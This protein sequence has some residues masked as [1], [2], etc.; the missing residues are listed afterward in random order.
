MRRQI[1]ESP[2]NSPRP[3][4]AQKHDQQL[5]W[6]RHSLWH[7]GGGA[8]GVVHQGHH[9]QLMD[10]EMWTIWGHTDGDDKKRVCPDQGGIGRD[11]QGGGDIGGPPR[12]GG[13]G[14]LLGG[15]VQ[16]WGSNFTKDW[17]HL[18]LHHLPT[19]FYQ[20][21]MKCPKCCLRLRLNP[22][23]LDFRFYWK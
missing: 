21:N 15:F 6:R 19:L 1:C 14:L 2:R 22:L 10:H 12:E 16:F 20:L 23:F 3:L 9:L 8:E 4:R 7:L 13:H 5:P 11:L 18:H 17:P